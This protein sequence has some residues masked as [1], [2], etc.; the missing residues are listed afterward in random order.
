MG[1]LW[2]LLWALWP[3]F[4]SFFFFEGENEKNTTWG[5]KI[6][7]LSLKIMYFS[8]L[9]SGTKSVWKHLHFQDEFAQ[10]FVDLLNFFV[11]GKSLFQNKVDW[12]TTRKKK[13]GKEGSLFSK[14]LLFLSFFH[15]C[16]V[17]IDVC[18]STKSGWDHTWFPRL[19][20]PL[21]WC[22]PTCNC[23]HYFPSRDRISEGGCGRVVA[24]PCKTP[25]LA[26]PRR[27]NTLQKKK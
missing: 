7:C 11:L 9:A 19:P 21:H 27:M 18:T 12:P 25:S 22:P 3:L 1:G 5:C 26:N 2:F 16:S 8:F 10:K 20:P 24:R 13:R 14:T 6:W 4:F 23:P 17:P 15:C